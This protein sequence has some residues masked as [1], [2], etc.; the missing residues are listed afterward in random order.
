MSS[1]LAAHALFL[2][3]QAKRELRRRLQGALAATPAPAPRDD[4]HDELKVRLDDLPPAAQPLLAPIDVRGTGEFSVDDF[5][6]AAELYQ[7]AQHSKIGIWWVFQ[8]LRVVVV[9]ALVIGCCW[10]VV[11]SQKDT[12]TT[13]SG[14]LLSTLSGRLVT[15]NA[16]V[17]YEA[18]PVTGSLPRARLLDLTHVV[19]SPAAADAGAAEVALRVAGV[20]VAVD[21]AGAPT[22]TAVTSAGDVHFAG[23]SA[24][25]SADWPAVARALGVAPFGAPPRASGMFGRANPFTGAPGAEEYQAAVAACE[26]RVVGGDSAKPPAGGAG[27]AEHARACGAKADFER[28]RQA[29][30]LASGGRE[31]E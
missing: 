26:F 23:G 27:G 25:A 31:P 12:R 2:G 30:L 6:A 10:A 1:A 11:T 14:A 15:V 29:A 20:M 7:A 3:A 24:A 22:V 19:L 4:E 28:R 9:A 21:A 16:R 13:A 8:L 18:L 17:T 5:K